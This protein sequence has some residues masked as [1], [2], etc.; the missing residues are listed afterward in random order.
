MSGFGAAATRFFAD[1]EEDNSREFWLANAD[2]YDR[3]VKQPMTAL[4]ESLPERYQPFRLYRMNR[5]LRFTRDKSPY[6][7]QQGAL[8]EAEG[9]DHYLHIDGSGLLAA[10]GAYQLEPD[11]LERFRAA[12][13]PRPRG[14][15][16]PGVLVGPRRGLRA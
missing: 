11:Q 2:R 6:K 7:T 13:L 10:A 8:S 14:G 15:Q 9:G 12:V 16:L 5:D 3:E 4:L 1:L